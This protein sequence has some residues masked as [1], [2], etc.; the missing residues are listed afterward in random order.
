MALAAM[1]DHEDWHYENQDHED[2]DHEDQEY[3][4]ED[5]RSAK[6]FGIFLAGSN[7]GVRCVPELLVG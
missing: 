4:G 5:K 3:E 1:E 7:L 6:G 2:R